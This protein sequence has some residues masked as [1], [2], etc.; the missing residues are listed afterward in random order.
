MKFSNKFHTFLKK[1]VSK[2]GNRYDYSKVE[3]INNAT[4]IC[5]ICAKHGEF[6]QTPVKHLKGQNCPR[7]ARNKKLTIIEFI[8]TANKKH[9]NRYD[10]SKAEYSNIDTKIYIICTKHGEFLQTPYEHL[11]GHGCLMCGNNSISQNEFIDYAKRKYGNL[12]DY[13][14]VD[15][16]NKK[17]PVIII[18]K[19]H[20]QF[21]Q[22]PS[23]HL[24]IGSCGCYKCVIDSRKNT[25]FGFV[26]SAVVVH[27]N[28]YDYSTTDYNGAFARIEII[29]YKH[30]RF[31]QRANDHLNNHGCP[32]CQTIISSGHRRLLELLPNELEIVINV[33][34]IMPPYEI[35]IWIPKYKLAIEYHGYYWHGINNRTII[36]RTRLRMKHY[37]KADSAN[38][39]GIKLLQIYD[40]E[41]ETK[42]NL[43]QSMIM[44]KLGLSKRVFARD[45]KI[46][47]DCHSEF[48]NNNHIQ[49]HREAAHHISLVY[50]GIIVAAMSFSI[51]KEYD[52]EIIR[53]C[54][55][56]GINVVGGFS[57][58]L[59]S[60]CRKFN[61]RSIISFSDRRY[62]N[63]NVYAA[64]GFIKIGTSKPNYKYIKNGIVLSRNKCQKNRLS[65]LLG[66]LYNEQLSESDNMITN[67]YTQLFDAGH[68]KWLFIIE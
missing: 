57:R 19:I 22:T 65:T 64:N 38:L 61:L 47:F 53:F 35:D 32:K 40:Y 50:D 23:K 20:G 28:K 42:I 6:L 46:Q 33:R 45:C 36:N 16:K 31:I 55:K 67:G 17:S 30:G 18:C 21:L 63:G 62:S 37:L 25:T 44:N 41:L 14:L 26:Q 27:G 60:F 48:Y 59:K 29:C 11:K 52:F 4:K 5:I 12:Y 8:E 58:C 66:S 15:Y 2:H 51:H 24:S 56:S 68:D 43:I 13:S 9:D 34:N 10:Y 3:Y 49:G 1:A 7:C 39:C 54:C